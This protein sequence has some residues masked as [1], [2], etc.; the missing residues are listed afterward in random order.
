MNEQQDNQRLVFVVHKHQATTLHEDFR[1]EIGGVMCTSAIP[2]GPTLNP[3][4]K[5]LAMP[6]NAGTLH[7][8]LKQEGMWGSI[9]VSLAFLLQDEARHCQHLEVLRYPLSRSLSHFSP[10]RDN[11]PVH[12]D[13]STIRGLTPL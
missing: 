9:L 11:C 3:Y 5:R 12:Q 4:L 10:R 13:R 1:L 2:K 8:R 6:S 7:L